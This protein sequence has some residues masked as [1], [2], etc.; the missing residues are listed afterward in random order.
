MKIYLSISVVPA[1]FVI[2]NYYFGMIDS[3]AHSLLPAEA[4]SFLVPVHFLSLLFSSP[5]I[6]FAMPIKYFSRH[7]Y[8][9]LRLLLA[10]DLLVTQL[11]HGEAF[12]LRFF[13]S[14]AYMPSIGLVYAPHYR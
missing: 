2:F 1:D 9:V 10:N 11:F 12:C 3:N 8:R 6:F 5:W 13:I 14:L 4:G 7:F